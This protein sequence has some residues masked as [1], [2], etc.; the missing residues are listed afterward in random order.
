MRQV[1]LNIETSALDQKGGSRIIELGAVEFIDGKPTGRQLHYH[2][3]PATALKT[4]MVEIIRPSKEPFSQFPSFTEHAKEALEFLSDAELVLFHGKFDI[5][6][7]EMEFALA[8]LPVPHFTKQIDIH[9]IASSVYSCKRRSLF[10]LSGLL[11]L[12]APRGNALD[13][14]SLIMSLYARLKIQ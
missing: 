9:D 6:F 12:E 2:F 4:G 8:G 3:N 1:S 5:Y 13:I 7:L 14:A 10:C 11:G